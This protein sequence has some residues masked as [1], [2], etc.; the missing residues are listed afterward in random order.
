MTDTSYL[1]EYF[2]ENSADCP[3]ESEDESSQKETDNQ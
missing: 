2:A 3:E 1:Y